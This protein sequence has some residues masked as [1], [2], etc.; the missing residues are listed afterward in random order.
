[1][2]NK[3]IFSYVLYY[4]IFCT[5]CETQEVRQVNVPVFERSYQK[6]S[7]QKQTRIE[8]A[9]LYMWL[10]K[11][12]L[13]LY[14]YQK[15][16]VL[17]V[18]QKTLKTLGF[19][20]A[21][22]EAP[23]EFQMVLDVF[24]QDSTLSLIDPI[25]MALTTLSN[26]GNVISYH[27]LSFQAIKAVLLSPSSLLIKGYDHYKKQNY[28]ALYTSKRDTLQYFESPMLDFDDGGISQDGF[29]VRNPQGSLCYVGAWLGQVLCF[30]AQGHF[31]KSFATIDRNEQPPATKKVNGYAQLLPKQNTSLTCMAAAANRQHLFVLSGV[32]GKGE[33]KEDFQNY[34][35]IDCYDINSGQYLYSYQIPVNKSQ[36]EIDALAASEE[37]LYLLQGERLAFYSF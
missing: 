14:D 22:G 1:M 29:F 17:Q 37:G 5:A 9:G 30:D 28:F 6:I 4:L 26:K 12:H 16:K 35:A 24:P 7:F 3:Y 21:E 32:R 20:G 8:V 27:K 18:E 33:R 2:H 25:N 36:E 19:L 31:M 23:G 13:W 11:S 34:N 15:K 10:G